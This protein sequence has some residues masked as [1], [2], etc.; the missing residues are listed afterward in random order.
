M[1]GGGEG[2]PKVA[3]LWQTGPAQYEAVRARLAG[4][5]SPAREHV[6][7]RPYLE[8]MGAVYA[9]AA[10]VVSRWVVGASGRRGTSGT[11]GTE[12]RPRRET[13]APPGPGR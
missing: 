5:P 12:R 13:D 1:A 6:H 4:L 2:H 11:S 10:L 7:L 8:D 3:V 9:A